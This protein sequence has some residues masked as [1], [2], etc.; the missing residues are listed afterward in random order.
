MLTTL[1]S[2]L[3]KKERDKRWK[4][5]DALKLREMLRGKPKLRR[6]RRRESRRMPRSRGLRKL[7]GRR[8][9]K[10]KSVAKKRKRLSL[11][12]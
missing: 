6:L 1:N 2:A 12:I 4:S 7:Q 3:N 11:D 10:N 9:N 8:E 5:R